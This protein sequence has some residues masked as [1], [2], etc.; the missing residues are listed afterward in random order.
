MVQNQKRTK[1]I[2]NPS[3][4]VRLVKP[5]YSCNQTPSFSP[6]IEKSRERKGL[7]ESESED[8]E[9]EVGIGSVVAVVVETSG[10]R[11]ESGAKPWRSLDF[12]V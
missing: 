9:V 1:A 5:R 12:E 3:G 7:T 11:R 4:Q 6:E 8:G 2:S 10:D